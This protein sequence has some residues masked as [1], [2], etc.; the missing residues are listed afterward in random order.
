VSR[1]THVFA[2]GTLLGHH[3]P[4]RQYVDHGVASLRD[5]LRD[6]SYGGWFAAVKGQ[7]PVLAQKASYDH[8][9]VVLAA[10]SAAIVGAAGADA[11]LEEALDVWEARFWQ[12]EYALGADLWDRAWA[13]L[14]PYRGVN[15]NMHA[16][17]AL[18]AAAD[19]TGDNIWLDRAFRIAENVV[20]GFARDAG[21]LL[22]EHYD[23]RWR[24]LVDYNVDNPRDQF[25]PYGVTIGHLFEWSRLCLHVRA[26]LGADAPPWLLDD[27]S[28][29]FEAG[30]QY[31]WGA[32]GAPGFVYTIDWEKQPV[33]TARLHWVI[34]EAIGAAAAFHHATGKAAYK[35]HYLR[36]WEEALRFIDLKEGSWRHEL[37]PQGNP[38]SDVWT[39]KPDI[40]HALQATLLPRVPLAPSLATALSHG[41]L[42][43]EGGVVLR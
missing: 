21:W 32:D 6:T 24:P 35:E 11:L 5:E 3:L 17:E 4:Y 36:W 14:D 8:A 7:S 34:A 43:S 31:G 13:Q 1:M 16:V 9:F 18:I 26:S 23:D 38:S 41:L 30:A 22:P 10:S 2:L 39:G 42:D 20:H 25:R 27:A 33:V 15:S 12:E 40:Y 29:L 28:G 19:V 37:D